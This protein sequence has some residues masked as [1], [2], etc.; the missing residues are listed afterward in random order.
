M[1][2]TIKKAIKLL[3]TVKEH[4]CSIRHRVERYFK[5]TQPYKC[6]PHGTKGI[7]AKDISVILL[8]LL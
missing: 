1:S 8:I 3:F 5:Q 2:I 4:G 7:A 6:N